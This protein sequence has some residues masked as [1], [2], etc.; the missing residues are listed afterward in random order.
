[1]DLVPVY[2][3]CI[4]EREAVF[5]GSAEERAQELNNF[6][7]NDSIKGIFD[8]SGGDVANEV[9]P[10]I[11][12]SCIAESNKEFWGYSDLTIILIVSIFLKYNYIYNY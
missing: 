4:Y 1:M 5:S 12:F 10:Y 7:K 2:S 9:L 6:Y 8:I 11:D 3:K